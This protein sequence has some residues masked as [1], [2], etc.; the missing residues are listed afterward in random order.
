VSAGRTGRTR[1]RSRERAETRASGARRGRSPGLRAAPREVSPGWRSGK[2]LSPR[3]GGFPS[4]GMGPPDRYMDPFDRRPPPPPGFPGP[5][6]MGPRGPL[7][8]H[9][10]GPLDFRGDPRGPPPGM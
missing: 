7:P 6:G 8:P 3:R 4:G 5:P 10:R 2:R 1:S 9:M